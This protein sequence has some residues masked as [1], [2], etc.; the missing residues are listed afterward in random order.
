MPGD[1]GLSLLGL[2]RPP[3]PSPSR[4]LQLRAASALHEQ[5]CPQLPRSWRPWAMAPIDMA[6]TVTPT[7]TKA[8][9]KVTMAGFYSASAFLPT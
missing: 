7:T 1:T 3:Y 5:S 2:L 9:K 6:R 8:A 4:R